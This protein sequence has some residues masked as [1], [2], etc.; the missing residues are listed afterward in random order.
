MLL[1][2]SIGIDEVGR[3][4][5]AGPVGVGGVICLPSFF[6]DLP[7][8]YSDINDSKKLSAWQRDRLATLIVAHPYIV[9]AIS[10]VSAKIIDRY[11]IVYA[12]RKASVE[13][14]EK[15]SALL[16]PH[17]DDTQTELSDDLSIV[18]DG[19][20]DYGLRAVLPYS[21]ETIIKWDQKVR[22][23]AAASI[24]AKVERDRYMT[25][26][27]KQ[28][29]YVVYWFERHKWYGTLFHRQ[30]IIESGL[31]DQHR[32]TFCKNFI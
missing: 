25:N 12:I 8:R 10:L 20:T 24:I 26:L 3:W 31:S 22:Q 21:L 23:I 19:K 32:K 5:L 4:P 11:G 30:M 28:K 18:L 7:E 14:I 17:L 13:V 27:S 1:S 9:S 16:S 29:K 2:N 6:T 15:I